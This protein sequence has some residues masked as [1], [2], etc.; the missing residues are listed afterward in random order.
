VVWRRVEGFHLGASAPLQRPERVETAESAAG[1][2]WK[3]EREELNVHSHQRERGDVV[4][5]RTASGN[6]EL[7]VSMAR[8]W[9]SQIFFGMGSDAVPFFPSKPVK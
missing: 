2:G 6:R 9:M 5:A 4:R 7:G 8:N 3:R 1:G